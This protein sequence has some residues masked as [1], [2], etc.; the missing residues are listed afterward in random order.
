MK[1]A[2]LSE[3]RIPSR[4]ANAVHVMKMC[5]A[6]SRLGHEVDLMAM[7]PREADGIASV[8]AAYGVE[9]TFGIHRRRVQSFGGAAIPYAIGNAGAA[10]TR[11]A[12]AV[13]GRD[14][15]ACTLAARRGTPTVWDTH[16]GVFLD[17]P[18]WRWVFRRFLAASGF[19]GVTTN[20]GT[21]RDA[22]VARIPEARGHVV[23]A[24]NG[25]DPAAAA[26][27]TTGIVPSDGRMKV[28]YVGQLYPGKG[29]ELIRTLAEGL[30]AADFHI[31]GGEEATISRLRSDTGLPSNLHLQG[32]VAPAE[33]SRY[34][35]S[36]DVLLAPYQRKV[37]VSGGGDTVEWMSP[38]KLFEYMAAGKPILCSDLPVLREIISDGQDG[39]LLS[40]DDPAAWL[41]ALRRLSGAPHERRRL[42][43]A[44]QTTQVS[45]FTW[46]HRARTLLGLL[47]AA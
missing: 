28:G 20:C 31:V 10:T 5:Q 15:L 38:L 46:E 36:F 23:A 43:A 29:L 44:A 40:P 21:L 18:H 1:I 17:K 6:L 30:P 39:L 25:A 4:E 13:L 8:H 42:G 34:V 32:Y 3:S 19:R 24:H 16:M 45:R 41:A 2:Y 33:T 22:I 47:N 14:L 9:P 11:R 35:Q 12:D 37:E 7:E 26:N 27:E